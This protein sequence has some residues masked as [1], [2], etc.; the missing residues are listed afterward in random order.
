MGAHVVE[1]VVKTMTKRRMHVAGANVLIMGLTF[2]ENCPDLRNTRVIDIIDELKEYN[3]N[4]DVYDPWVNPEEAQHEYGIS[5][6]PE[7]KQNHYDAI[8]VAVNHKQFYDMGA[9]N[10]RKLGND[11]VVLFDVKSMLPRDSVDDRL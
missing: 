5:P 10:I 3:A 7:L 11:N 8:I 1:R 2:K 4:I 6:I 9:D